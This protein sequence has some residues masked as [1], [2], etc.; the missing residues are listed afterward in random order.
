MEHLP[1]HVLSLILRKAGHDARVSCF[2]L[3]KAM[4][5]AATH[6]SVWVESVCIYRP[7]HAAAEFLRRPGMCVSE[8]RIGPSASTDVVWMLN[9]IIPLPTITTLHIE[10]VGTHIPA[11]FFAP[12]AGM[13]GLEELHVDFAPGAD[14]VTLEAPVLPSLR[15]LELVQPMPITVGYRFGLQSFEKL[16]T[17]RVDARRC[18]VLRS[19]TPRLKTLSFRSPKETHRQIKLEPE[20]SFDFLELDLHPK[21]SIHRVT[22]QLQ[23]LRHIGKLVL[24]C[25]T[26]FHFSAPFLGLQQLHLLLSLPAT[27]VDFEYDAVAQSPLLKQVDVTVD[28]SRLYGLTSVRFVGVPSVPS[29]IALFQEKQFHLGRCTMLEVCPDE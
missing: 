20:G 14:M 1:C 12:L 17:V 25:S 9:A 23:R 7:S 8:L 28:E 19:K 13:P 21:V 15:H 4:F 29:G 27:A 3:S 6:P 18:D 11:S 26:D 2:V 22:R 5:A 16:E 10:T 24:H